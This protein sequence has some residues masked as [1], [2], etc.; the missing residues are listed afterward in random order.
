M[1][2]RVFLSL[3]FHDVLLAPTRGLAAKV[4]SAAGML[5]VEAL[6]VSFCRIIGCY[7]GK[8]L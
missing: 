6:A 5:A 1:F 8:D 2:F 7:A 3:V 4:S